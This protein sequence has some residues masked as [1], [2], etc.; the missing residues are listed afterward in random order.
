MTVKELSAAL[1][2]TEFS[3]PAPEAEVTGGYAGDL[4]SWV[5]GRARAGDCWIT[6]MSNQ[7][8]AAEAV[9]ADVACILLSEG[10][11]PDEALLTKAR[12]QGINLLGSGKGT[13]ELA[14]DVGEKMKS[15]E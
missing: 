9:M 11:K 6:I 4:L 5:M 3:L 13:F 1:S 7:N 2:L 14:H 12:Q 8:V 10:V 15:Q